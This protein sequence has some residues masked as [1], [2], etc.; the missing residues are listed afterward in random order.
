MS[1][2]ETNQQP[3]LFNLKSETVVISYST[4]SIAGVPQFSYRDATREVSRSGEDI[5]R[6][7]TEIGTLVT[8]DVEAIPDLQTVSFTLVLPTINLGPGNRPVALQTIGVRTTNHTT[9][10][11]PGPIVGPVQTYETFE[12]RGTAQYVTF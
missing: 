9:I 7:V 3:N 12:L 5:R 8:I 10:A 6:V 1:N 2:S 4:T 11:G